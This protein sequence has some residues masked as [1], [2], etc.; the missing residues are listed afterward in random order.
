LNLKLN[1]KVLSKAVNIAEFPLT[2]TDP[3]QVAMVEQLQQ[4]EQAQ[5]AGVGGL[6]FEDEQHNTHTLQALNM[7]RKNRHFC[8]VIL[9]VST[10]LGNTVAAS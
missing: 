1:S 5:V 3:H 6:V 8:D 2:G 9:H 10:A 7:M 4:N